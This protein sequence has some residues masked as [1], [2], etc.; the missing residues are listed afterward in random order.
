MEYFF[1]F[2]WL[3]TEAFSK[4]GSFLCY[5]IALGEVDTVFLDY[6]LMGNTF[7]WEVLNVFTS[8]V[9]TVTIYS[10]GAVF[11][12]VLSSM[13]AQGVII[14]YILESFIG[15]FENVFKFIGHAVYVVLFGL[16][17]AVPLWVSL[18]LVTP[19]FLIFMSVFKFFKNF[20]S[21][22]AS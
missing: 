22:V 1:S 10:Y 16:P 19:R 12:S 8:E 3:I 9:E 6:I 21:D 18:I 2:E 5:I 14:P 7:T 15:L 4:V 20:I 11:D 13:Q 17:I